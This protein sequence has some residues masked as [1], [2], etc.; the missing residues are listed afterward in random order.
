VAWKEA[1]FLPLLRL[2][3]LITM[4]FKPV[5]FFGV[6]VE[7]MLLDRDMLGL[8]V[9]A[10]VGVEVRGLGMSEKSSSIDEFNN[11]KEFDVSIEAVAKSELLKFGQPHL[12]QIHE[13]LP[14]L[15]QSVS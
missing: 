9:L 6:R 12:K 13:K 14:V 2:L 1:C 3:Q 7:N 4:A 11:E 8:L 10:R 5:R 15:L